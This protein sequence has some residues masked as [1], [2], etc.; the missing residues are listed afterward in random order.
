MSVRVREKAFSLCLAPTI[1]TS[2]LSPLPAIC[3]PQRPLFVNLGD[4]QVIARVKV[5][6]R[7]AGSVWTFPFRVEVG[8][9]LPPGVPISPEK[10]TPLQQASR[11]L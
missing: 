10:D 4:V 8:S 11:L 6:G 9:F 1:G 3:A 5:N 7:E 2:P